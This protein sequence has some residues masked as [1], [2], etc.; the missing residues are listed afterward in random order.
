MSKDTSHSRLSG[1]DVSLNESFITTINLSANPLFEPDKDKGEAMCSTEAKFV[2]KSKTR[3][4]VVLAVSSNTEDDSLESSVPYSYLIEAFASVELKTTRDPETE[5]ED[6]NYIFAFGLQVLVGTIREQLLTLSGRGPWNRH[7]IKLDI[8][9]PHDIMKNAE[10][11]DL[12][13]EI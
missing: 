5:Q 7:S 1:S 12:T 2:K 3:F 10:F 6:H 8:C 11:L 4:L 9:H 13:E